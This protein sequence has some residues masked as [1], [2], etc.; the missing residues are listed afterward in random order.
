MCSVMATSCRKSNSWCLL[1]HRPRGCLVQDIWY[2]MSRTG[3]MVLVW[4]LIT[5]LGPIALGPTR[6]YTI[7][8]STTWYV[9]SGTSTIYRSAKGY[10]PLIRYVAPWKFFRY[11]VQLYSSRGPDSNKVYPY[12]KISPSTERIFTLHEKSTLCMSTFPV[13][14]NSALLKLPVGGNST[15]DTV[16]SPIEIFRYPLQLYSSRGPDSNEVYPYRKIS[17]STER[18]FTLHEKSTLCMSTFEIEATGRG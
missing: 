18:I 13:A 7:P 4:Y 12:R 15:V 10:L 3:C 11:P 5:C 6:L 1:Q 17:P 8:V 9:V 2:R 16:S 14:W